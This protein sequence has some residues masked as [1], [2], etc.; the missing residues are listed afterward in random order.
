MARLPCTPTAEAKMRDALDSPPVGKLCVRHG[1]AVHELSVHALDAADIMRFNAAQRVGN[2]QAPRRA[3][4]ALV[5]GAKAFCFRTPHDE[6]V[7]AGAY[8][9]P[10][11]EPAESI[12]P[13]EPAEPASAPHTAGAFDV[14]DTLD[15]PDALD[16]KTAPDLPA[17]VQQLAV[18]EHAAASGLLTAQQAETFAFLWHRCY[19]ALFP[20]H[21]AVLDNFKTRNV[22]KRWQHITLQQHR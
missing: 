20:D 1:P 17:A 9:T 12:E 8:A 7:L 16:T 21:A 14:L 6:V 3:P 5:A 2:S 4:F 18:V 15:A 13:I 10:D 22:L 11:T 19:S